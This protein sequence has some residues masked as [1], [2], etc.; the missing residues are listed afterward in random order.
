[1]RRSR[2]TFSNVTA[3]LAL[4]VALGGTSYAALRITGAQIR[5]GTLSGVDVKNESVAARDVG[6]GGLSGSDLKAGSLTGGD[7]G[8]GSLTSTD[9]DNGSLAAA[10]L[11]PGALPAGPAGQQGPAGPQGPVGPQGASGPTG[12]VARRAEET[13]APGSTESEVAS[14]EPGETAVGGGADMTGPPDEALVFASEPLA[15]DGSPPS[16]GDVPTKWRTFAQNGTT[17]P[18]T[19]VVEV[20]CAPAP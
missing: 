17:D 19:M 9:V 6:D 1:M 12:V 14:C 5:D 15:A 7:V 4:F 10:D 16:S 13:I 11:L 20:L 3:T 2:T 18:Q 8:D